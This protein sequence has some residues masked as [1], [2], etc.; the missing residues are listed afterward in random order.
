MRIL[1]TGSRD[2]SWDG[3]LYRRLDAYVAGAP[4]PIVVVHGDCPTGAD[5]FAQLWAERYHN[6]VAEPHPALW[7]ED[8]YPQ[9]GPMR[10]QRMV[11]LG[12]DVCIAFPLGVSRGTRDCM[13]RARKAGIPVIDFGDGVS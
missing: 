11:D 6:A 7:K 5:H 2:W 9:A 8:G 10:N 13:A 4:G 3:E 1:V 12:A